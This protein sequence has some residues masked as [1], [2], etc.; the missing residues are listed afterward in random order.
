MRIAADDA[1]I[2]DLL[3]LAR[4]DAGRETTELE[5]VDARALVRDAAEQATAMGGA[6]NVRVKLE[7]DPEELPIRANKAKLRRLLMI[8]VDNAV[9]FTSDGGTVTLS[10]SRDGAR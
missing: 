6:K 5:V 9:K 2:D 7:L 8:L 3:L 10:A 4:G 1:L